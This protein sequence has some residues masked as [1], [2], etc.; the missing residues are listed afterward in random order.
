ME[1]LHEDAIY[2]LAS[3]EP[4]NKLFACRFKKTKPPKKMNMIKKKRKKCCMYVCPEKIDNLYL[5]RNCG[6]KK[7]V[8]LE[9][10]KV[11]VKLFPLVRLV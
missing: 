8:K 2:D 7:L 5:D 1:W 9:N 6:Q 3:H 4:K 11:T 10:S